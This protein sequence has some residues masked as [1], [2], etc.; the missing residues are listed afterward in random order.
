[1]TYIQQSV[2]KIKNSGFN[3][4]VLSIEAGIP[5]KSAHNFLKGMNSTRD[6]IKALEEAVD[7]LT[8]EVSNES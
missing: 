8:S 4:N 5:V 2:D 1:M 7:R 6:T 3:A